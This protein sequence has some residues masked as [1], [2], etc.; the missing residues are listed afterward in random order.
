MRPI[1]N[2]SNLLVLF[3]MA[4]MI[5]FPFLGQIH[6]FDWDATLIASVSKEMY[7]RNE[8]LEPFLGESYFLE[9]P[10]FFFWTQLISFKYLGINEYAARFPNAICLLFIM[11]TFYRNGKRLFSSYFGMMWSM[12][13]LSM[14]LVQFYHKSGLVEPWFNFFIYLALYNLSRVIEMQQERGENYYK[15]RD[16][17]LGVFYAGLAT[18]GAILTKGLEGFIIVLFSYWLCFFFSS[19]KYG[20]GF[21]NFFKWIGYISLFLSVWIL[22]EYYWHGTAY[23]NAF[24]QYQLNEL[25][26]HKASFR[27]N[28]T[29]QIVILFIGCFPAAVFALNSLKVN[30]YESTIQKV[31]RLMMVSSLIIILLIVTFFKIKII[32][33]ASFAYFPISF[34]AAYSIRYIFEE[35]VK[36]KL[37]TWIFLMVIGLI[38]TGLLFIVPTSRDHLDFLGK[39]FQDEILH[40]ALK[41]E[42]PWREYE[43][44]FGVVYFLF[45]AM[46]IILLFKNK[47]RYGIILIFFLT[48]IIS[49][50]VL[51]YYV[52]KIEQ[53]TQGAQVDFVLQNKSENAQFY[54]LNGRSYIPNFYS[55]YSQKIDT[56]DSKKFSKKM[57]EGEVIYLI[58]NSLDSSYNQELKTK[59]NFL[60]HHGIY[61][62]YKLK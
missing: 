41:M 22:V 23:L 46:G 4:G 52:P 1:F 9:K 3:I 12:I 8:V 47:M 10:P 38:W 5:A 2:L 35:K 48:M 42:Y 28:A 60:Y 62:F 7:M 25:D 61:S 13:Y 54:Y 20:T 51:V 21:K 18:A 14:F 19:A 24:F 53:L 33:Y 49:E 36:L 29:I 57:K 30:T 16:I 17:E 44:F 56:F 11:L 58:N 31:F 6:L 32:H 59:A 40:N 27:D 50:I 37:Y 34:M 55:E 45:F 26:I 43:K 15:N 39:Y